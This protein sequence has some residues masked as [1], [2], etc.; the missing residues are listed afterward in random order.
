MLELN[1]GVVDAEVVVQALFHVSQNALTDRWRDIRNRDV[2]GKR[3]SFRSNAPAVKVVDIVDPF[4]QLG[5][6]SPPTPASRLAACLRA[7][8]STFSR[9]IPKPDH[10]ISAPIP[11]D[12]A[13]S[14]Q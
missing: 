1:R 3:P 10:K 13:E 2:A 11:N 12:S 5:W 4:D 6:L 14:I 7:E 9:T 8:C